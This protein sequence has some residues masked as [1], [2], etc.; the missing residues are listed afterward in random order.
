MGTHTSSLAWPNMLDVSR[1]TVA[2]YDGNRSIVNRT[3][4]LILT[5]PTELYNS[6]TFGVGLK[7][8]LWQYNTANTKAIIQ[9]RI[10]DQL[11]EHE[12]YVDADKTSFADGLMFT[13]GGDTDAI[14]ERANQIKMTV[15]LQTIYKDELDVVVNIEQEQ[16]KMFGTQEV[17]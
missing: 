13:G 3:K 7:R 6:P 8:Y 5:E 15:G 12:P 11:R 9:D 16:D 2:V 1:N 10:K 14:Y 4:L 17:K